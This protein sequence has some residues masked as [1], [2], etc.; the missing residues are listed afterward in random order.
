MLAGLVLLVAGLHRAAT[1][2]LAAALT[3]TLVP[4]A[5][6]YTI[7]HDVVLLLVERPRGLVQLAGGQR[8]PVSAVPA[9]GV[10]AGIQIAAVLAGHV[11]A[12][13]AAHDRSIALLPAHRRLADQVPLVLL[14]VAY[15]W[16]GSSCS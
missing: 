6:S 13:V 8:G 9:P 11:V 16:R 12:V 10:V 2:A 5:A 14:M 3:S 15:T 4:I 1:G 7:A